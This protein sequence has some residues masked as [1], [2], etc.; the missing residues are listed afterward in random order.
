VLLRLCSLTEALKFAFG[1]RMLLGDPAFVNGTTEQVDKML[2]KSLANELFSRIVEE[3][4]FQP[5]YYVSSQRTLN[6]VTFCLFDEI[7]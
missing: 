6:E 2:S 1:E 3:Q 4:T 7:V 5:S